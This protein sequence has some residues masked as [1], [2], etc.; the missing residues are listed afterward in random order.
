MI[1]KTYTLMTVV[2]TRSVRQTLLL[3][4][5]SWRTLSGAALLAVVLHPAVNRLQ[6]FVAELYPVSDEIKMMLER[7]FK[8]APNFWLLVLLIAV[9]PA[10]C[11]ELAFRGF[12]LSGFRH[13]GHKWRAIVYSALFFGLTHAV[14][15]QSL[16]ACLV[17]VVI[18][19]IAVQ[20]GSILPCMIFHVLHNTLA[21][22][23]AQ[24]T[25]EMLQRR[26]LLGTMMTPGA[27]G[28]CV[29]SWQLVV[30]GILAAGLLLAWFGRLRYA[31]S[32]EEERRQAARRGLC[33][34]DD[35]D[36]MKLL[37]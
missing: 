7:F 36:I 33:N 14:I 12:I 13:L 2:L 25:R 28:G 4:L 9:M 26:P 37:P 32:P 24:I 8:Q 29:Y 30:F 6:V 17:G 15:Q 18:G 19:Y 10:I 20:S 1:G 22:A 16:I 31:K 27:E 23:T 3:R 11:E 35:L 34:D 5:P 21:L